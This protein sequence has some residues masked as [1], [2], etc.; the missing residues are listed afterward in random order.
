MK[1]SITIL[2]P[3]MMP[4]FNAKELLYAFIFHNFEFNNFLIL[5]TMLDVS[6][7]NKSKVT[8]LFIFLWPLTRLKQDTWS[9][10]IKIPNMEYKSIQYFIHTKLKFHVEVYDNY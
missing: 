6:W 8:N 1:L 2:D 7:L 10:I 9:M 5:I 3:Y 4:H